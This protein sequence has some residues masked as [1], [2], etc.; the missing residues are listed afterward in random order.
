VAAQERAATRVVA[1]RPLLEYQGTAHRL[2]QC[3]IDL[4]V[5]RAGV[6][7]AASGEDDGEPASY[8]APA[9]A[10]A[11]VSCALDCAHTVVQIFGAAGTSHPAIVGLFRAAYA[12]PAL[13]SAPRELWRSAGTRRM[14]LGTT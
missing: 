8:Q 6:R 11:S 5:A 4:A 12:L 14:R 1:N 10:A 9:S 7:R 3:A 13:T 2:A